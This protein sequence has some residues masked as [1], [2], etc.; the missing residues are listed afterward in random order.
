VCSSDLTAYF[1]SLEAVILRGFSHEAGS[2]TTDSTIV[3]R[4]T[5]GNFGIFDSVFTRIVSTTLMTTSTFSTIVFSSQ[6]L[7]ISS[8]SMTS[9][10]TNFVNAF[11]LYTNTLLFSRINVPT[12]STNVLSTTNLGTSF[13]HILDISYTVLPGNTFSFQ[14]LYTDTVCTPT[15]SSILFAREMNIDFISTNQVSSSHFLASTFSTVYMV[16]STSFISSL[17]IQRL[18]D[19]TA[20]VTSL[21][22]SDTSTAFFLS[23]VPYIENLSTDTVSSA[24]GFLSSFASESLLTRNFTMSTMPFVFFSTNRLDSREMN[25]FSVDIRSFSTVFLNFSNL[26][27]TSLRTLRVNFINLASENLVVSTFSMSTFATISTLQLNSFSTLLATADEITALQASLRYVEADS[28]ESETMNAFDASIAFVSTPLLSS[29]R[30]FAS[31]G[32]AS[33]ITSKFISSGV[34]I[35]REEVLADTIVARNTNIVAF[36]VGDSIATS[37]IRPIVFANVPSVSTIV[38]SSIFGTIPQ[39]VAS[40]TSI[41]LLSTPSVST[42]TVFAFTSLIR[43]VSTSL[44]SSLNMV[45]HE[46]D[47]SDMAAGA[48]S[49]GTS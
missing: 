46:G 25:P 48:I 11:D 18:E 6:M 14:E 47:F 26:T 38:Y 34:F 20:F 39:V 1:S 12:W 15:T 23:R 8:M 10:S 36:T 40:T 37:S 4:L 42:D 31:E 9:F 22:L 19:Y 33:S 24:R 28:F 17:V 32:E 21:F 35:I 44:I 3:F 30:L 43:I 2:L 45:S 16:G 29:L 5:E 41:R 7:A 27:T 49:T 13:G